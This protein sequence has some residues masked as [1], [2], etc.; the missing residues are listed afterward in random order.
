VHFPNPNAQLRQAYLQSVNPGTDLN[1]LQKPA[2]ESDGFSFAQLR[3]SVV[4]AAQFAFETDAEIVEHHLLSG[5]RT[6]R[7]TMVQS[8]QHCNAAGFSNS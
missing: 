3:E 7:N 8:S 4:L 5:I 1:A 6:L 2:E